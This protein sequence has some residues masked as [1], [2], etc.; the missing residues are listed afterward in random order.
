MRAMKRIGAPLDDL[1]RVRREVMQESLES[2]VRRLFATVEVD[3]LPPDPG[4]EGFH[5]V[6][7]RQEPSLLFRGE[8]LDLLRAL[9][10]ALAA[11][12]LAQGGPSRKAMEKLLVDA[13]TT[14]VLE[15]E[16]AALDLIRSRL[17]EPVA[18]WTV[19]EAIWA[20]VPARDLRLGACHLF[21]TLPDELVAGP[22]FESA[23]GQL[24]GPVAVVEVEARDQASAQ[25]IAEDRIA[26]A[27]SILWLAS[28][29]RGSTPRQLVLHPDERVSIAGGRVSLIASSL[30]DDEGRVHPILRGLSDAAGREDRHRTDWETR[31]IAASRWCANSAESLWPSEALVSC[32]AALESLFVKNRH[33]RFKG[34]EIAARVSERW[35]FKGWTRDRQR[36]WLQNLYRERNNA[37]HQGRRYVEDLEVERLTDVTA[38]AVTWG[39]WHLAVDHAETGKPCATFDEVMAHDLVEPNES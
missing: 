30:W 18:K 6:G 5:Y 25:L 24:E 27:R 10:R 39:A 21:P 14:N 23:A 1:A 31:V 37:I 32:M 36:A 7:F 19:A 8:A 16:E 4:V 34:K 13:C 22:I 3:E 35:L 11:S 29:Q 33:V 15:G 20:Y 2:D 26:E 17:A 38:Q 12:A 28:G 9:Q